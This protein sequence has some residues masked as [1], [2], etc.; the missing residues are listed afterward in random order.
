MTYGVQFPMFE[1]IRVKGAQA[2]P[3]YREL[4]IQGGGAPSW[5]FHK[6]LIGRDGRVVQAFGSR[7]GPDA[8]ELRQAIDEA[9][10]IPAPE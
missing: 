2:D 10:A 7:I 9:L 5:N 6:F 8:K 3:F 4:A 1:K